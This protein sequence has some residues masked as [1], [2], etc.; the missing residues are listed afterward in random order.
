[1]SVTSQSTFSRLSLFSPC[2]IRMQC[3]GFLSSAAWPLSPTTL[4][5]NSLIVDDELFSNRALLTL[6]KW[7]IDSE[8]QQK[9][10]AAVVGTVGKRSDA[11]PRIGIR[12]HALHSD[13]R[14]VCKTG[15]IFTC[16]VRIQA[17]CLLFQY[18]ILRILDDK[19][20]HNNTE[21]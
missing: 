13:Q 2:I 10:T 8:T 17:M 16:S 11:G 7:N 21:T 20:L 6:G 12:L 15:G 19:A 5:S 14:N 9:Q 1:M 3:S 4:L 18:S